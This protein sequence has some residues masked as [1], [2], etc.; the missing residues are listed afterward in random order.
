MQFTPGIAN[1]EGCSNTAGNMAW[2]DFSSAVQP[3]GKSLYATILA[4]AASGESVSMGVS[5]C[6]DNNQLPL[7]YRVDLHLHY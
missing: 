6:A 2:I 4:A 1:L 7:V 3:D 5:G